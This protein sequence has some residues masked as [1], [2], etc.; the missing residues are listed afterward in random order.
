MLSTF[1]GIDV[2]PPAFLGLPDPFTAQAVPTSVIRFKDDAE[3][4]DTVL[5]S[6][7]TG[8]PFSRVV[9]RI[10]R[11]DEHGNFDRVRERVRGHDRPGPWQARP[12]LGAVD[13]RR[14][15]PPPIGP[16]TDG[17]IYRVSRTGV[18][19]K[20][21][22]PVG[23]LTEPGGIEFAS[24]SNALLVSKKGTHAEDGEGLRSSCRRACSSPGARASA[25]PADGPAMA[26]GP[27]LVAETL[28]NGDTYA[29]TR[30]LRPDPALRLETGDRRILVV[31]GFDV[32]LARRSSPATEAWSRE[33]FE[34]EER[35]AGGRDHRLR[36]R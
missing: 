14:L 36:A 11:V 30:F 33:G 7:L 19:T 10:H 25:P 23:T 26:E 5:V 35:A 31:T 18:T 28:A 21:A 15:P 29:A 16:S 8:F 13:R 9:H 3:G 12:P 24:R 32:E 1:E 22:L 4:D 6:E 27:L 2:S 17:A 34:A 20:L